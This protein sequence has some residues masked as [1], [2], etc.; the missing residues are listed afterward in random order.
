MDEE[1]ALKAFCS[2]NRYHYLESALFFPDGKSMM[3][4]ELLRFT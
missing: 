3:E 4:L 1:K 2:N